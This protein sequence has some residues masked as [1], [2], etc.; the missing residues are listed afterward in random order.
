MEKSEIERVARA[1]A[2][3]YVPHV[4]DGRI[5]SREELEINWEEWIDGAKAAIAAMKEH[6]VEKWRGMYH[7]AAMRAMAMEEALKAA[8]V[9]YQKGVLN[10]T[11]EEID[12]AIA[13]R[14]SALSGERAGM[15]CWRCKFGETLPQDG[16]I[17][18]SRMKK[19]PAIRDKSFFCADWEPKR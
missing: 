14:K 6:D 10:A 9:V 2:A 11:N 5:L 15:V 12:R 16:S 18:C 19:F 3:E 4:F 17:L 7:V 13:L 1:L 8:E